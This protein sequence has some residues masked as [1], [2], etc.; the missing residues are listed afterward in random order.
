MRRICIIVLCFFFL[1]L[2]NR[3]SA[4]EVFRDDFDQTISSQWQIHQGSDQQLFFASGEQKLRG[5]KG[6]KVAFNSGIYAILEKHFPSAISNALVRIF[7][8]DSANTSENNTSF[9]TAKASSSGPAFSIGVHTTVSRDKY[10]ANIN[11]NPII[12]KV[13]RTPGWHMFEIIVTSD[14]TY[15]KIDGTLINLDP[16]RIGFGNDGTNSQLISAT[17]INSFSVIQLES[18]NGF[19]GTRYWDDL[20]VNTM[21]TASWQDIFWQR[22]DEYYRIYSSTN[23]SG[24]IRTITGAT[25]LRLRSNMAL[26]FYLYGVKRGNLGAKQQG[27]AMMQAIITD[28]S[29]IGSWTRGAS[30]LPFIRAA[31]A[32]KTY[33]PESSLQTV[34]TI[35]ADQ[36]TKI[37]SSD[38]G[39]PKPQNGYNGDTK[40]E[41]NAWDAAFLASAANFFPE[42]PG[43][44]AW[45]T[46]ARCIGFHT[47]TRGISSEDTYCNKLTQTV[48]T[49]FTLKNHGIVSP[50]Y[51]NGTLLMLAQAVQS[52]EL[53]GKPVPSQY[54]HNVVNLFTNFIRPKIDANTFYW[55]YVPSD[56]SG[57]WNTFGVYGLSVLDLV[58]KAGGDVSSVNKDT[59]MRK[60]DL[61][62]HTIP[63]SYRKGEVAESSIASYDVNN[64]QVLDWFLNSIIAG[65]YYSTVAFQL[66]IVPDAPTPTSFSSPIHT[67][68]PPH[69]STPTVTLKP[70]RIQTPTSKPKLKEKLG[71]A[72]NDK[73]VNED[74][75]RIWRS[76]YRLFSNLG[77]SA[78]DFNHD[79]KI[80]GV[81]Y[82]IW[83]KNVGQ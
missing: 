23:F 64:P 7:Y 63:G 37:L 25:E 8:Y 66:G 82:V 28:F 81:D 44:S 61:F 46:Q 39:V 43:S 74:D 27:I 17:N 48:Y 72:N 5:E 14:G 2:P 70:A 80:N 10:V 38:P 65:E 19:Y 60:M 34:R 16:R 3:A 83:M 68:I 45:E 77:V 31:Y 67:A 11:G 18:L 56:W 22:F 36:A 62:F 69:I 6:L 29:A 32:M 13:S 41:E 75:Y 9:L 1:P 73:M 78:G 53:V 71:D 24:I 30:V 15:G 51:A 47:I 55:K 58:Q 59:F 33:L 54:Y 76:N 12:T 4:A 40:A 49:D 21:S 79:G 50:T 52:Y 26:Y 35:I 42:I 57:I 20:T